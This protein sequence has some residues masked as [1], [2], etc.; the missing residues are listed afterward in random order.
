MNR[1][2][3]WY[4]G[5][6]NAGLLG[7]CL[8]CAG[9]TLNHIWIGYAAGAL[10]GTLMYVGYRWIFQFTTWGRDD[11]KAAEQEITPQ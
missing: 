10:L 6:A 4:L 8:G 2:L 5:G 3:W 1:N 7:G 9:I 11:A